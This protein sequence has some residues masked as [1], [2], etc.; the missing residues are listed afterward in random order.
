MRISDWSSDV[1]S[2][3]LPEYEVERVALVRVV[4]VAAPLRGEP[5]HLL[6]RVARHRPAVGEAGDVEV[7]GT[8]GLVGVALVE[9][10]PDEPTDVGD[11]R[12]RARLAPGRD[13]AEPLEGVVA[14][15]RSGPGQVTVGPAPLA[16]SAE[17]P[18]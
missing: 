4:D 8:A 7:D 12:R 3:D 10:H 2:S 13:Q 15:G 6:A 11:C 16:T 5:E 18:G 17:S 14:P 1:C 9:H